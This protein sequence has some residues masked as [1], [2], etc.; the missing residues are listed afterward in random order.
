M[1]GHVDWRADIDVGVAR[2]ESD[3]KQWRLRDP[4]VLRAAL[5]AVGQW[6]WK[7]TRARARTEESIEAA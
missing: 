3:L 4:I 2:S 7:K 1:V 5:E 6:F